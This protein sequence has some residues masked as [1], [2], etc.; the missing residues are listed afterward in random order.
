MSI[1]TSSE[2]ARPLQVAAPQH[3]LAGVTHSKPLVSLPP[4]PVPEML[5]SACPSGVATFIVGLDHPFAQALVDAECRYF[6]EAAVLFDVAGATQLF[7]FMVI[8]VDG[9][10]R[11]VIRI[12]APMLSGRDDLLPFAIT[13]LA[14]ADPLFRLDEV[15]A[16]YQAR[17]IGLDEMISVETQFRLGAQ[18]HPLKAGDL[19]YLALIRLM[20]ENGI[21]AAVAHVNKA[22]VSSFKRVSMDFHPLAHR[23]DLRTPTINEDGTAGFDRDYFPVCIPLESNRNLLDGLAAFTPELYWA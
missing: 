10:V 16:F 7:K 5:R 18:L 15:A 3:G 22:T 8:T 23:V 17:G 19:G 6:D 21:K 13:D 20:S 12:S 2:E 9:E 1:S 4:L 11:H 14:A